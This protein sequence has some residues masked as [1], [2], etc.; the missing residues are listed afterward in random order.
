LVT[1][2]G[3]A[4]RIA[5]LA[6]A[7]GLVGNHCLTF[8]LKST[9]YDKVLALVRR[10]LELQHP[11]LQQFIVNF[12]SLPLL[13]EFAGADVF[14]ALGTTMRQA[15]SRGAFR[16]VDYDAE[17]A[18][19]T[20]AATGGANQFLLVSSVG[21]SAHSSTFYL[22]VKGELEDAVKKLLF[23]SIHIFRPSF[24][25][26][27]RKLERVGESLGTA[28]AQA[29]DFAFVGIFKKY[30]AVEADD[31]AAAMLAVARKAEAGVHYYEFEQI[32]ALAKSGT[33]PTNGIL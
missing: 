4:P 2:F 21:A 33:N 28:V 9:H 10:P 23:S 17:L 13:P 8:L 22:Q 18:Y 3:A 31:L 19:A 29:L 1:S 7:S 12:E 11:K 30:S 16:K 5:V 27:D 24:L 25:V 15:G 6:G 26:G 32:L 20:V 14:C